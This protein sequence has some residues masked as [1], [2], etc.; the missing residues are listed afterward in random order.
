MNVVSERRDGGGSGSA[1][2]VTARGN[3]SRLGTRCVDNG[4]RPVMTRSRNLV[5]LVGIAAALGLTGV[6][7]VARLNAAGLDDLGYVVMV[8]LLST[9]ASAAATA[10]L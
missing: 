10:I 2:G 8:G 9:P 5:I 1:A 3:A 4:I 6:L 7:G